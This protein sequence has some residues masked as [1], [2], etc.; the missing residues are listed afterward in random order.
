M[1]DNKL[2]KSGK[3]VLLDNITHYLEKTGMKIGELEAAC[4]VSTGY[5]SRLYKEKRA[6]PSLD[7]VMHV[8]KVF[9]V[10]VDQLVYM[11]LSKTTATEVYIYQFLQKLEKDTAVDALSWKEEHVADFYGDLESRH[12]E[13][14]HPLLTYGQMVDETDEGNYVN[15]EG[16]G[17][18]SHH[19]GSNTIFPGT[20]YALPLPHGV[21]LYLMPAKKPYLAPDSPEASTVEVWM[22]SPE[23]DKKYL[24]ST[25][26]KSVLSTMTDELY[27]AVLAYCKRP[28][29]SSTFQA[30]IDAFMA[31]DPPET[32]V[33]K[34][35]THGN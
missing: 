15:A 2:E 5:I 9:H 8:S 28:N 33:T 17:F 18:V 4:G 32:V 6:K 35:E 1:S 19:F 24:C 7:F 30:A 34:E 27:H 11:D 16:I 14:D 22:V 31:G 20:S 21:C 3:S 13:V 25:L 26:D 23:G 10:S 12:Y 29:L